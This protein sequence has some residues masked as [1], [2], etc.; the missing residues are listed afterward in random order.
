MSKSAI[1]FISDIHYCEDT[2][3]SQ[4]RESDDNEY[5][6]KW[7]NCIAD[8]EKTKDVK[9]KYLVISG[10]LVETG[11]R[12]EYRILR[13]IL[14]KFCKKFQISKKNIL[15]IPGNH[16]INRSSLEAYCDA[17]NKDESEAAKFY[18][19]KLKNYIEFYREFYNKVEGKNDF[20]ASNAILDSILIEEEGVLILGLNSLVKESHSTHVGYVDVQKLNEEIMR[21]LKDKKAIFV[22]T[23]HSFTDTSDRELATIENVEPLKDVLGLKGINTFIYGHHHTSESKKDVIGDQEDTLRYIEIG[24]IGKILSNSNGESYNNRF[25]IAICESG[26]FNVYDYNY[27]AGGWEERTNRKYSHELPIVSRTKHM[28]DEDEVKEL[29]RAKVD[30]S[31]ENQI[32]SK[33]EVYIYEKSNFLFEYLKRDGNYKEG[34][35]HWKD[36]KK[37]L[38]WINIASFLGNIDI[39]E[40]IK[41]CIIDIF[42]Q[43]MSGVSVAVGYGMEGNII[44]SSLVDY[45]V[46]NNIKY[47][48]YPSVHKD[49]EHIDLEKSLWNDYDEYES[50]LL[51]CDIMPPEEYLIEIIKSNTKLEA[52]SKIYVLS[53]CTNFNLLELNEGN[54]LGKEIK[55]YSLVEFNVPVCEKNEEECLICK[56]G[57]SKIYS[58]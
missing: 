52:C 46:E 7:E 26:K 18:D 56:Q 30:S 27:T 11:K 54:I 31:I 38:G 1:V 44:G 55:R 33:Y 8:I 41:E 19:I 20:D 53:L 28:I 25:T 12:R 17:E 21:Y 35:F 47:Y 50:V 24:S 5:Y 49:N 22:V 48:F 43:N 23:H 15:L 57:L 13:T 2:T 4:F 42:E 3:K 32:S 10:D 9:V 51:I 40:K 37:T 58:L 39:L 14:D 34:H 29:P 6:Q 45:W 36:K 16:D